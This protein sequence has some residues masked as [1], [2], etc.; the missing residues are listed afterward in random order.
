MAQIYPKYSLNTA[1]I[2]PKVQP[3]YSLKYS[4]STVV[5][6]DGRPGDGGSTA[7][8][9][10]QIWPNM[11]NWGTWPSWD[12]LGPPSVGGPVYPPLAEQ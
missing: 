10:S 2:H 5:P 3:K 8:E 12:L 1:Q 7:A 4:P 9:S 11:A 6:L